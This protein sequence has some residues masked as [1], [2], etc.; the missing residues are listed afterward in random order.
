[1]AEEPLVSIGIPN[2]NYGRYLRQCVES[3]LNQ[4][5]T[6]LECVVVENHS[7]DD[8]L[9]VLSSFDDPRLTIIRNKKTVPL[10]QNWNIAW[11]AL[12]GE[13]VKLLQSD[14]LL[15]PTY[16]KRCVD[17]M[18]DTSVD[19]VFSGWHLIDG[20]SQ[21]IGKVTEIPAFDDGA[22]EGPSKAL[23][24]R[25]LSSFVQPTNWLFRKAAAPFLDFESLPQ[26]YDNPFSVDFV[27]WA[28]L[29]VAARAV[30]GISEPLAVQRLHG[31]NDRGSRDS[32]S[33]VHEQLM[34]IE[35]IKSIAAPKDYAE[36]DRW[37]A[38]IAGHFLLYGIK[39]ALLG[40]P[41]KLKTVMMW[42]RHHRAT[43]LA[44]RG[45]E[46]R[47][48]DVLSD[49]TTSNFPD[50]IDFSDSLKAKL[51]SVFRRLF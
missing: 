5:Y 32:S 34:G 7:D 41:E 45:F 2:Y 49:H 14:D 44:V 46:Y 26:S 48:A 36:F 51:K 35:L 4:T 38:S 1:M 33:S 50:V 8:S 39:H 21:T 18:L 31:A 29:L 28:R 30:S 37:M 12:N 19:L 24:A 6:N 42:I 27:L 11:N 9:D 23:S 40:K 25:R 22:L 47:L 13:Y 10:Y 15:E 20:R 3:V 16:V 43:T 17:Q